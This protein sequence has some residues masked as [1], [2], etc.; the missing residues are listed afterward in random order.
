M[1]AV[2]VWGVVA[3]VLLTPLWIA[4]SSP[5]LQWREPVYVA[6]GFA[7]VVGLGLLF[8][9]PLLAGRLLPGIANATARRWHGWVGGGL[10]LAVLIHV[11]GLWIT[12][13][14]DVIDALTFTSPTP[15]SAWGVIAMWATLAAA[16]VAFW[17]H[18]PALRR[19][20]LAHL[21]LTATVVMTTVVHAAL[22]EG[23][24]GQLSKLVLCCAA[25]GAIAKVTYDRRA[26][27]LGRKRSETG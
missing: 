23:T 26:W 16:V 3:A 21:I 8:I 24:M 22:I 6:A 10:L 25:L 11:A 7:G 19:R 14:P 2:G 17:G 9:Q 4:A 5:L 12:S 13:P 27:F 20:R 1:R 15:F 18:N